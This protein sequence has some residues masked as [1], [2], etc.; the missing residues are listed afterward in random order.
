MKGMVKMANSILSTQNIQDA[1]GAVATYI[2]TCQSLFSQL[3][4]ELNKLT[5]SNFDGQAS[6]GYMQ[7]FQQIRP[8]LTQ[9][10]FEPGTSLSYKL[11]QILD[12][13]ENALLHQV[14]P[15]L[16]RANIQAGSP[17]QPQQ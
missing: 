5:P 9:N 8:A 16:G 3:E 1:K 11:D 17:E 15:A 6:Q 12:G 13:V 4:A 7:F 2:S 14:D 10:L